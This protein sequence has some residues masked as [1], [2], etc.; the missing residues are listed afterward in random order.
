MTNLIYYNFQNGDFVR[1]SSAVGIRPHS[2][3]FFYAKYFSREELIRRSQFELL[4]IKSAPNQHSS[5]LISLLVPKK[6][7]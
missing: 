4:S 5:L 2:D 6:S 7:K 3:E 1:R